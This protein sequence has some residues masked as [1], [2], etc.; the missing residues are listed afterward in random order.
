M[1][2]D[3]SAAAGGC[4]QSAGATAGIKVTSTG[5]TPSGMRAWIY[6]NVIECHGGNGADGI[7]VVDGTDV[8]IGE[9]VAGNA[10]TSQRNTIRENARSGVRLIWWFGSCGTQ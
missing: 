7:V 3:D 1:I 2:G 5:P 6:G 4:G 10:G 8:V 9:D